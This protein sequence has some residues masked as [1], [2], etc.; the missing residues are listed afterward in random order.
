MTEIISDLKKGTTKFSRVWKILL[1]LNLLGWLLLAVAG[2]TGLM[3]IGWFV[4]VV[5]LTALLFGKAALNY[6]DS[7]DKEED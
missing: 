4:W 3:F 7:D 2:L 1:W 6:F 5:P